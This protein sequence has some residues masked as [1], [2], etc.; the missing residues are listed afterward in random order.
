MD[1]LCDEYLRVKRVRVENIIRGMSYFFSVVLRGNE[2]ER[3]M[4]S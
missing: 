3:E 4:V 2:N 1:R